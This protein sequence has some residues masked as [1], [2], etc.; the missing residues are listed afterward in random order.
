MVR[1]VP[2][3]RAIEL[4]VAGVAAT[5]RAR[6]ALSAPLDGAVPPLRVEVKG[7]VSLQPLLDE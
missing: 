5:V 2:D 3:G 4:S 6:L 1:P 7:C